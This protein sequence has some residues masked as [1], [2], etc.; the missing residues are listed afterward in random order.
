M[1]IVIELKDDEIIEYLNRYKS[2]EDFILMI[3]R[4]HAKQYKRIKEKKK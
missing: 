1:K 3:L 2:K 4:R